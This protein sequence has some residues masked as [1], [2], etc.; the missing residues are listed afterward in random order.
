MIGKTQPS[1]LPS[2]TADRRRFLKTAG[3]GLAAILASGRAPALA[4][5]APTK[6]VFAHNA[7]AP[8]AGAVVMDWFCK[9]VNSRSKGDID[10]QFFGGTLISKE[11]E[12]ANAVKSGSVALGT[13]SGGAATIVPEFGVFVVPYLVPDYKTAYA[14]FNGQIGQRFDE[15]FQKK[16]DL[17]V[18]FFYDN[19]FR[20][21]WNNKRAIVEPKDLRGLKLRAQPGRIFADAINGLGGNA[22]PLPFSELVTAAQQGVI[23][24]GDMPIANFVPVKLYEVSKY[25]SMSY[26]VYSP[27]YVVINPKIWQGLTDAQRK[28]LSEVGRDAQNRMRQ[29]MS[30]VDSLEGAKTLL[31]PHGMSVNQVDIE[32]FRKT[33]KENIWPQYQKQYA[34]G[35]DEIA[36][37]KA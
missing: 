28:L 17:K 21:F 26:H 8:E 15:L 29:T 33:A 20:H 9:E 10:V 14:M 24:G 7:A 32:L 22:V 37:F 13:A 6:L 25:A 1:Q 11:I 3:T 23:D 35:W 19:G 5:T 27:S 16:Y 31:E 30:S 34:D 4:Q 2:T 12:I 18:L 36:N